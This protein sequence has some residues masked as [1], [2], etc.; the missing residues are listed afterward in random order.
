QL[1]LCLTTASLNPHSQNESQIFLSHHA[2]R[3]CSL[4]DSEEALTLHAPNPRQPSVIE[5]EHA[6]SARRF[7]DV[8]PSS[9]EEEEEED[10][11]F[12]ISMLNF[13]GN[14]KFKR[15]LQK[16][17]HKS[18]EWVTNRMDRV[19]LSCTFFLSFLKCIHHFF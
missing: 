17:I 2:T 3:R 6:L 13:L 5:I 9:L 8:D 7:H 11:K 1:W 16:K 4:D 19:R 10:T 15:P 12:G 18:S 14:G